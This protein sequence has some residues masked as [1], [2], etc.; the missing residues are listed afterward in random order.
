MKKYSKADSNDRLVG[1]FEEKQVIKSAEEIK[2]GES[3]AELA[4]SK[5]QLSPMASM[6][7]PLIQN[8]FGVIN[9]FT[10]QNPLMPRRLQ[11][12]ISFQ[13]LEK[14]IEKEAQVQQVTEMVMGQILAAKQE[15]SVSTDSKVVIY[16]NLFIPSF[17]HL[18]I[19][20]F[21]LEQELNQHFRLTF[22]AVVSE[23]ENDHA[24]YYS[25]V[26]TQVEVDYALAG[27]SERKKMFQGVVTDIKVRTVANVSTLYVTAHSNTIMLDA[28]KESH[29]YQDTAYTYES[30]VNKVLKRNQNAKASFTQEARSSTGQF[31]LQ[32]KET[33]WNFIKRIASLKNLPLIPSYTSETPEF[34]Y[35]CIFNEKIQKA[36]IIEYTAEK[37]IFTFQED[38]ENYINGIHEKEYIT[39]E[40]HS[41]KLYHL[42]DAIEF[43]NTIF[44][45]R[46]AVYEM[47][48]GVV[49]GTYQLGRKNHFKQRKFYNREISGISIEGQ[50]TSISRDKVKVNLTIDYDESTAVYLFPYSTMSASPDG[51]G[52]Y[53]MPKVGD[54]VRVYF[55]DVDEKNCY[56]V[57]SVSS[58]SP[59]GGSNDRMSDPNVRY[60]RTPH[61]MEIKLEPTGITIDAYDGKATIILDQEG[62]INIVGTK[63][64]NV[65]ATENIMMNAS[66]NICMYATEEISLD[67]AKGKIVLE[68]SGN[69]RITGEY[70]LEN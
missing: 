39:Y 43:K 68:K 35:G 10:V 42:G 22:S 41:Y 2:G 37:N 65:T 56:A 55:P 38:K 20:N 21:K 18:Y 47:V 31:I 50:V 54:Q 28:L 8:Q 67:G 44:Y 30:I 69:T 40:I 27:F 13:E 24:V 11:N 63:N 32:Y 29:S 6:S 49:I 1:G 53:C 7:K 5:E 17:S 60:L 46:K 25:K 4:N 61:G 66:K 19:E 26:G 36:D 57:S 12:D 9:A 62:N 70:V 33:D 51:S 14:Q 3:F 52:W 15:K 23:D 64:V 59:E 16:E 34:S 58:Y 48:D 45:V